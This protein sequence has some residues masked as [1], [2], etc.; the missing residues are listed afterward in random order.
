MLKFKGNVYAVIDEMREFADKDKDGNRLSTKT[1]HRVTQISIQYQ[2]GKIPV[3]LVVNG[4]D[5]PANFQLPKE[6]AEWETPELREVKRVS[7]LV[8][9]CRI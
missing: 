3:I 8:C 7:P 9:D 5:L 1:S 2:N 4:W 6:G